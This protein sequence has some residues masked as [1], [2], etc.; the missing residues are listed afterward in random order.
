MM[1]EIAR[2]GPQLLFFNADMIMVYSDSSA[3]ANREE[4]SRQYAFWCG[5]V[6]QLIEC[7][8]CLVA[9]P[10]NHEFQQKKPVKM[11][12]RTNEKLWRDNMGACCSTCHCSPR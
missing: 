5:M 10:G 12:L 8:T 4:I 2:Q 9:V 7:G 1:R 11:A 6:S 3:R